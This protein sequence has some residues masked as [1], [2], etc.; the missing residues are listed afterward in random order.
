MIL[1][2][3]QIKSNQKN[4][5]KNLNEHY[6]LI[7][8]ASDYG[9][10]I[11]SFPEMSITGYLR[12]GSEALAFNP[13]DSRLDK[14]RKLSNNY[15]MI[16]IVGSPIH[17]ESN[18][19]IGSFIIKPD[20]F[21]SIYTK[22]YLHIGE[23]E[24]F[25]SSSEYNPIINIDNERISFAI[26]ADIDNPLHP[27]AARARNST[28]YILGIFFSKNGISAC[29]NTLRKYAKKHSLNILMSNYCGPHWGVEAGGR[30]AFWSANGELIAELDDTNPGL[31]IIK[32]DKQTWLRDAII[33]L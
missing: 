20:S 13:N 15:N 29:H 27:E 33:Y 17:I 6:R 8:I 14:L 23:D 9:A 32:K 16:I 5:I 4:I 26:C 21:I 28:V 3:A 25:Q 24:F 22:Q 2:A 12:E 30:S 11:I 31:L 1:V 10:D 7:E 18:L 19:Y